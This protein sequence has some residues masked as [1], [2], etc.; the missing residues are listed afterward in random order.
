MKSLFVLLPL[1]CLCILG[2]HCKP[3]DAPS[4]I[5]YNGRFFTADSSHTDVTALAIRGDRI[6]ALGQDRNIR[7]M[8]GKSTQMIDLQGAFAMPGFIE[9]HGHFAALGKSLQNLNLLNT[10]NWQEITAAVREKTSGLP[11][12]AWLEGRGWHQEKWNTAPG[13]TVHGYPYH[14][15]LSAASPEHPVVLFHASGHSLMANAR[16]MALA[17]V[18]PATP[19][20]AGGRIVRDEQGRLCGVFEENA[21]ELIEKPYRDWLNRR[22]EAEKKA[23]F[24]QH[25]QMATRECLS[26]GITSFQDAGSDFWELAQ[27]ESMAQN[28]ALGL[29]LWAMALQPKKSEF[30]KL[31]AYP[32]I[33]LGNGFFTCRAV[34][35]YLD[36]AL[37]SY[38]AWLLAAY[39]DKPGHFGQNVTPLDTVLALAQQCS[40]L[41]LQFCVHGIGDRANYELLR[42]YEQI[43]D[44][45][46]R[47]WR[48]EHAQ[49]LDPEDILRFKP[50][51]IIASM[52][53][54]H[55]PSDAAFAEKRLG[56]E[57]IAAGAY[58]WRQLLDAGVHLAN[59]TDAPVEA[60]DPLPCLYAALTRRLA[61]NAGKENPGQALAGGV[62]TR[63]EALNSYTIWNAWAAFEEKEKGSLS[64]GKFADIVVLSKDLLLCPV[65]DIP[66]AQVLKTFIGGKL[67]YEASR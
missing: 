59:G 44:I 62:M 64:P 35:A 2:W 9:G 63:T 38:G 57:R 48:I 16:A 20:P 40:T 52:Q 34:K 66:Q 58:A 8:A 19:D 31:K 47:R 50:S 29:R 1:A 21:M 7:A 30:E 15:Q 36:G 10:A 67:V 23:A 4:L 37:G 55:C 12:G 28:G 42:L 18:S 3:A 56:P 61:I 27:Y 6:V 65:A 22:S 33:G 46:Q 39:S 43:P 14:D 5:L 13:P 60:V 32:K 53:A 25:V 17:G 24:E 26:K 45:A 49:H 51:G 54:V 41:G 11:P